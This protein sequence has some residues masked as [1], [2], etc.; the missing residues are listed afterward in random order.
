MGCDSNAGVYV[1]TAYVKY[2]KDLSTAVLCSQIHYWYKPSKNNATKL[3]VSHAGK[4]WIAKSRREW[5]SETGLTEAQIRRGLDVLVRRGII[6]VFKKK[7]NGAPTIHVRALHVSGSK[8]TDGQFLIPNH[9]LIPDN[10]D[11]DSSLDIDSQFKL[12]DS[13]SDATDSQSIT[14]TKQVDTKNEQEMASNDAISTFQEPKPKY[15]EQNLKGIEEAN[16]VEVWNSLATVYKEEYGTFLPLTLKDKK[17]LHSVVERMGDVA[18]SVL[19]AVFQKWKVFT[20]FAQKNHGAYSLPLKP[21]PLFLYKYAEAAFNY[22]EEKVAPPKEKKLI[23]PPCAKPD[24]VYVPVA[25]KTVAPKD[26]DD[27]PITLQELLDLKPI[28]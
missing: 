9:Q 4:L 20:A 2:L 19:R 3:R 25:T 28:V 15:P 23:S 11:V 16:F 7:F 14:G 18:P 21:T 24:P 6:E 10:A 8:L 1:Q 13:K 22:W 5:S 12:T 27:Q 17:L 26:D